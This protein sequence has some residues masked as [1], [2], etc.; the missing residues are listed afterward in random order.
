[1]HNDTSRPLRRG[2]SSAFCYGVCA[3]FAY[4]AMLP[5]TLVRVLA[6]LIIT[7]TFPYAFFIYIGLWLTLPRWEIE[8][9]D[10][11]TALFDDEH[12]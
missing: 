11:T 3:G 8:P 5:V 2:V 12:R 7:T 9:D 4:Y 6:A 1:M 10:F